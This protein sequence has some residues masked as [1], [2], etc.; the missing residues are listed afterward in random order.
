MV[1]EDNN[2]EGDALLF[3]EDDKVSSLD[4]KKSGKPKKS[5]VVADISET[6]IKV[7]RGNSK[8]MA[9][10]DIVIRIKKPG[11]L[12]VERLAWSIVVIILL[13]MVFKG[14]S[15]DWTPNLTIPNI[16]DVKTTEE[17][18]VDNTP[19][20]ESNIVTN[21]S[22]IDIESNDTELILNDTDTTKK[23]EDE[24]AVKDT[25]VTCSED[26]LDVV[27]SKI[28]SNDNKL[29]KISVKVTAGDEDLVGYGI[30]LGAK[31]PDTT[32]YIKILSSSNSKGILYF[33]AG[34]IEKCKSKV[35]AFTKFS[36]SYYSIDDDTNF[37]VELRNVDGDKLAYATKSHD[38]S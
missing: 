7:H 35:L 2:F 17:I 33:Q 34:K 32:N 4:K 26:D 19:D 10:D 22:D 3:E 6:K 18:V 12:F 25:P 16:T 11:K 13:I 5:K 14:S 23:E 1:D 37:K 27:I 38:F 28:Y 8:K 36:P 30:Y 29:T 9:N 31:V 24:T 21:D 15:C 20:D